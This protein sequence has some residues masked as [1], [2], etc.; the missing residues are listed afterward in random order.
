[1]FGIINEA[2]V[3]TIGEE[4]IRHFYYQAVTMMRSITG[5]GAGNG[6]VISIHDGFLGQAKWVGFLKGADRVALDT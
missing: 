1:M 6:P 5:Y 3:A 4:A 2:Y